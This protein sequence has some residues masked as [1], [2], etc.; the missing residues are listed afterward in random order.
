MVT[1][2][3]ALSAEEKAAIVAFAERAPQLTPERQQELADLLPRLTRSQ[4]GHA[5]QRL[6]GLARVFWVGVEPL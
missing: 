5:V 4:G 6:L 2:D 3:L 1:P